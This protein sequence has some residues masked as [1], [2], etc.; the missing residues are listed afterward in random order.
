MCCQPV[1]MSTCIWR[2]GSEGHHAAISIGH[3]DAFKFRTGPLRETSCP[4]VRRVPSALPALTCVFA[5][6]I[7]QLA[8][9]V[10]SQDAELKH[11]QAARH[12]SDDIAITA[13]ASSPWAFLGCIAPHETHLGLWPVPDWGASRPGCDCALCFGM[14]NVRSWSRWAELG[15]IVGVAGCVWVHRRANPLITN[16]LCRWDSRSS[17]SSDYTYSDVECKRQ[18]ACSRQ[19]CQRRGRKGGLGK[20]RASNLVLCIKCS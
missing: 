12:Q 19:A 10:Q 15:Q 2:K 9:I 8:A 14:G 13:G 6:M 20:A 16:N 7:P 18:C 4:P 1:A 11:L 17:D 3:S 5:G